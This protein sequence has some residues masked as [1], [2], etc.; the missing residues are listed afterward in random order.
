[1]QVGT[2]KDNTY[3][4]IQN[5]IVIIAMN[6]GWVTAVVDDGGTSGLFGKYIAVLHIHF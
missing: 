5:A 6:Q 3:T 2:R 1:M 4:Q